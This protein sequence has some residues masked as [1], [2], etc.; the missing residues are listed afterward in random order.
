MLKELQH[1]KTARVR[2]T[3]VHVI[4]QISYKKGCLATVIEH[5]NSWDNKELT[6][7][8]VE[9]II[10]VHLRYIDFAVLTQKEVIDYI[11]KHYKSK[12]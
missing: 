7:K 9:E 1:E 4:G 10:D 5:L 6:D 11:S 2:N 12:T 8:A 3:L